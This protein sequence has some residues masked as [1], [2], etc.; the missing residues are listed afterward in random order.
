M[1]QLRA[2]SLSLHD[3]V[4]S[5]R[6]LDFGGGKSYQ[7]RGEPKG[8]RCVDARPIF[9]VPKTT[10]WPRGPGFAPLGANEKRHIA[11][12]CVARCKKEKLDCILHA[13]QL[14][15]SF[16]DA[17]AKAFSKIGAAPLAMS[18]IALFS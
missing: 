17:E 16:K 14:V 1:P 13:E 10:Y 6:V 2:G 15:H 7:P 3:V 4:S 12:Q 11:M 5:V 8:A 18:S 9:R